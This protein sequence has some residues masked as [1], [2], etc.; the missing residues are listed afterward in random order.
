MNHNAW[1]NW[2]LYVVTGHLQIADHIFRE[3]GD[4]VRNSARMFRAAHPVNRTIYR[5]MVLDDD[6]IK[7]NGTYV[8]LD[9][10]DK[11][12]SVSWSCEESVARRFADPKDELSVFLSYKKKRPIGLLA[13][14]HSSDFEVLFFYEW[15]M[16]FD[17]N[18]AAQM[19]PDIDENAF[20]HC[21]QT[22][23]E[24]I[25]RPEKTTYKI[26]GRSTR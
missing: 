26:V 10:L 14:A 22:Q 2:T 13:E 24:V 8:E 5:G 9:P 18:R 7:G 19:H 21:L 3:M 1:I 23:Y 16:H 17:L 20:I 15:A 4:D 25:T 12:E 6:E 11:I